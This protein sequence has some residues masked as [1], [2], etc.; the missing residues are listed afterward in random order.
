V[1]DPQWSYLTSVPLED[2]RA[3]LSDPSSEW[4]VP[5]LRGETRLCFSM[6]EPQIAC[7]GATNVSATIRRDADE[8]VINGR[9]W[10]TAH[11]RRA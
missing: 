6:T 2:L 3:A 7:Y 9:K 10:W 1:S 11:A 8:F 4:L 5:W